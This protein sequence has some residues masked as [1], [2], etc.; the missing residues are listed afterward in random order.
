MTVRE[1]L[2]LYQPGHSLPRALYLDPEI[3]QRELDAI[4]RRGWLFAGHSCEIPRPGDY[5]LYE[6]DTDS[7]LV[8]RTESGV[9]AAHHNVCR[10]RGSLVVTAKAGRARRLVCPYHQWT[11]GLDGAL[12]TCRGMP[13]GLD[14]SAY[15][16]KPVHVREVA[17]LIFLSLADA[18]LDFAPAQQVLEPMARPQGLDRARIAHAADYAV[19]AN[20]KIVWENNR[21]CYHCNACHPQ[22]VKA[23]FD[24]YDAD[25][26]S[27]EV[28]RQIAAATERSR[29]RWE[30]Q[31]LLAAPAH[32]GLYRFP[33]AAHNLWCSANRTALVEGY[34]TE[35]LD[36]RPVAPLMG[37]YADADVGT[38]RMRTLPNF[39]C[40]ASGDHAVTTRLTPAGPRLTS[41]RVT[42]LVNA[43]AR[44]GRDYALDALLPF[45]QLTS[46]QDWEICER[47]QRGV[48][49]RAYQPGPLSPGKEYNV[50]EF[51]RWTIHQ[52]THS[53]APL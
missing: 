49:S 42:W 10:H 53:A 4:W 15:G 24:R 20:W 22:Y 30:A 16:L 17:G 5:F 33:D 44:E 29:A 14:K 18:P 34:V 26:L 43:E 3:Y 11:Y 8:V 46:E 32:A 1:L 25:Q 52:L 36:G 48:D 19:Q 31:G 38:L 9:L 21:E 50:D 41:I 7:I 27:A 40:H 39:W 51:L 13:A 23:N 12:L 35:S 47:V 6:V 28:E 2:S 37:D 45:W